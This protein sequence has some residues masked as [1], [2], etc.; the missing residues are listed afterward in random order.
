MKKKLESIFISKWLENLTLCKTCNK[1]QDLK[2]NLPKEKW[3]CSCN[4]RKKN[5]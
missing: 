4:E 5:E 1:M 2:N 3:L